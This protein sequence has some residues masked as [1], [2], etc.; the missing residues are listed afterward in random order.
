MNEKNIFVL[1]IGGIPGGGKTYLSNKIISEYK[2]IYE[3]KYLNFDL[4]ENINKDNYLQYQQMRNDYLLKIQEIFDNEINISTKNNNNN[5]NKSLL[6][7]LDDNFFLKSMRKKIYNAILDKIYQNNNNDKNNNN[8]Y[9]IYYVEILLKVDINYCL[10]MNSNRNENQKIPNDIIIN[11]NSIFEYKSPYIN[12]TNN[13]IVNINDEKDLN[14]NNIIN[15]IKD[16]FN[17]NKEKYLIKQK[18]KEVKKEII[19]EKDIKAKLIDDIEDIIRKE[20][21]NIFKSNKYNKKKGKEI[22]IY[23]KE[24]MKLIINY[25]RN[26]EQNNNNND[27]DINKSDLFKLFDEC[28]INNISFSEKENHLKILKEDFLNYLLEKQLIT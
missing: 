4:I 27:E 6:I 8:I 10:K 15:L 24:Y 20:I 23:K 25:I 16:I 18:I 11:M 5:N 22:S 21:N 2:D 17:N 7:I 26:M 28:I 12:N 14:N 9:N 1:L 3:I 19:I 13:I